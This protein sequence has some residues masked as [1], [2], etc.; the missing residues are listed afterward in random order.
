MR[1]SISDQDLTDYAL[2][3]LR[4]EERLYVESMLAVSEECRNDVYEMIE[5]AQLLERGFEAQEAK[6]PGMLTDEQRAKL[7]HI[8]ETTPV[9]RTAA[10]VLGLAACVAFALTISSV[11]ANPRT[12][13][14]VAQVS[15][16][17]SKLVTQAVMPE[18]VEF[19]R[20]FNTL[21]AIA[22]DPSRW[23]PSEMLGDASVI[24]TPPTNF[25]VKP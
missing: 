15:T 6:L 2:N 9:W 11:S 14:S 4:P 13:G 17:M 23:L 8:E 16:Q 3:E 19:A 20:S 25:D 24:C 21:R 22:E 5:V 10:A 7:L 1:G 12:E 18:K